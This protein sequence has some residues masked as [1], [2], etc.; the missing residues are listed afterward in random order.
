[1]T[2]AS[3]ATTQRFN[4]NGS[5]TSF[6]FAYPYYA[7]TDFKVYIGNTLQTLTTHYAVNPTG[8]L[9]EGKYPG[10]NIVFVTAPVAGS[11]NVRIS[12]RVTAVQNTDISNVTQLNT[13]DVETTLDKVV[14]IAQ[15]SVDNANQVVDSAISAAVTAAE[16]AIVGDVSAAA[17][18]AASASSSASTATTQAGIATTQA[19]NASGSASSASTSATLAGNYANYSE[20]NLVPGGSGYSALHWRNKAEDQ[21]L[22]AAG[23]I[24]AIDDLTAGVYLAWESRT[25]NFTAVYGGRY[26]ADTTSNGIT[27]TLPS[28]P[29]VLTEVEIFTNAT[30]D[31]PLTISN[32][33][34]AVSGYETNPLIITRVAFLKLKYDPVLTK[35]V[36]LNYSEAP[37]RF[38]QVAGN[39][40]SGSGSEVRPG[41]YIYVDS[42]SGARSIDA[43]YGA[44]WP[45][46]GDEFTVVDHK[47]TFATNNCTIVFNPKKLE[48]VAQNLVISQNGLSFT[49]RYIDD[50]TGWTWVR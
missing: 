27:V 33:P 7:N 35:W 29:S 45:E 41:D 30:D 12:R 21:Y 42:T 8:S 5:Q 22:L 38:R 23:L 37:K 36:W 6:N 2:V 44:N 14:I 24:E 3:V 17:A 15:D 11:L 46:I 1:M 34:V 48:G 9:S 18:S 43:P 31:N 49:F 4:G 28:S 19:S 26:F 10:A 50:T 47:G 25:S 39:L 16:A 13:T 40:T 32:S 20:D